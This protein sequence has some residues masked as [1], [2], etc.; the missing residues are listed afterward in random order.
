MAHHKMAVSSLPALAYSQAVVSARSAT[1]R[2]QIE[3]FFIRRAHWEVFDRQIGKAFPLL[4]PAANDDR[5]ARKEPVDPGPR[6]PIA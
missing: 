3:I 5:E 1:D 4:D 2:E 6:K